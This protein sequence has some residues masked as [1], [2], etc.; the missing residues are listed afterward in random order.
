[1]KRP[2]PIETSISFIAEHYPDCEAAFLAGSAGRGAAKPSSDLDIVIIHKKIKNSFRKSFYYQ[3]WPVE[4][5][6]HGPLSYQKIFLSDRRRAIPS[7]Q[8]MIFEGRII[9]DEGLAGSVKKA[10][11][12][13]LL[14][15]PDEW[16]DK[17]KQLKR[18]FI[19]DA[20]ADLT[21]SDSKEESL[22]IVHTLTDLLYEFYMRTNGQWLG[23]GKWKYRTL[24]NCDP[25]FAAKLYE[26][27]TSFNK[28]GNAEQLIQ[29]ADQILKPFGGRYFEGFQIG[30]EGIQ[31]EKIR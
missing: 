4:L 20:L 6:A 30:S 26:S 23:A 14:K 27:L 24:K 18:Y 7:M 29:L 3:G 10:A 21:D 13:D 28:D 12:E 11:E 5:F 16:A 9:K 22:F 8:R 19:S 15:G 31:G 1:M 17:E 2:D 25:H